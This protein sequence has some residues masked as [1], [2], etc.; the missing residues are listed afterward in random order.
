MS[1][2]LPGAVSLADLPGAVNVEIGRN[3]CSSPALTLDPG[4][5]AQVVGQRIVAAR[6]REVSAQAF[7][8]APRR[9]IKMQHG[10]T[11]QHQRIAQRG[12]QR[13]EQPALD[14]ARRD[15]E[16]ARQAPPAH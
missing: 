14:T 11:I 10:A 13:I 9:Q 1:P 2:A 8:R 16:F 12:R 7:Q 15:R 6:P 5:P 4:P 3:S